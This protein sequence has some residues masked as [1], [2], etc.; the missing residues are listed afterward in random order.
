MLQVEYTTQFKRDF[1]LSKHRKKNLKALQEVMKLIENEE[2]L[3]PKW[4]DHVL[5]GNWI[6]HRELHINPD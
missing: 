5:S 3:A 4:K 6:G 1:K 2:P